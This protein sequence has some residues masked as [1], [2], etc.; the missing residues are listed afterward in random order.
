[1]YICTK[2]KRIVMNDFLEDLKKYFENTPEEEVLRLWEKSAELDS[3]GVTMSD[4]LRNL[5]RYH[6]TFTPPN[7]EIKNRFETNIN[8]KFTSGFFLI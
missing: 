4:F 5:N 1:M 7:P 2:T 3:I 8:P 6:F